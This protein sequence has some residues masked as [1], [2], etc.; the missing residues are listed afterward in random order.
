MPQL[1]FPFFPSGS[2][3]INDNIAF[4]KRDGKIYYFQTNLPIFVHDEND[5]NTFRFI[6]SQLHV[7]GVVTQA[8]IVKAFGVSPISVKRAVKL[9]REKGP[10]GFYAPRNFRGP[11]VLTPDVIEEAQN[12]LDEG[13]IISEVAEKLGIKKDT[14]KKAVKSGRL[15]AMSKKKTLK[16]QPPKVLV[17]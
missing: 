16:L 13:E 3:L 14:F 1:H 17:I 2:S 7:N 9:F 8:E 4:Q 11:G 10:I 5:V 12:L 6:T 15:H